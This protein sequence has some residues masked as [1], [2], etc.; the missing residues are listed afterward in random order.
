MWSKTSDSHHDA[1]SLENGVAE[2]VACGEADVARGE[3]GLGDD[4]A[5]FVAGDVR[6]DHSALQGDN[7]PPD[8][9]ALAVDAL[10]GV[11]ARRLRSVGEIGQL[12]PSLAAEIGVRAPGVDADH[13][14]DIDRDLRT[15]L[16][17]RGGRTRE[18]SAGRVAE[19]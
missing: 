10:G 15:V 12:T 13:E 18:G 16:L 9:T 17:R 1:G 14:R 5:A 19:H 2:A 8:G 11:D 6:E 3:V 7:V 4:R